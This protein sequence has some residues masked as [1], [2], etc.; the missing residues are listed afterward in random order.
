MHYRRPA[1]HQCLRLF[2]A[3]ANRY[4]T[5]GMDVHRL[6]ARAGRDAGW[7]RASQAELRERHL[8]KPGQR[9]IDR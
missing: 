8:R 5:A 9:D 3:D 6:S 4:R 7:R 1:R 2:H